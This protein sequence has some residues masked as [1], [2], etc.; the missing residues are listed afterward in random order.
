MLQVSSQLPDCGERPVLRVA[1]TLDL[2]GAQALLI[3][4]DD[5]SGKAPGGVD[6]DLGGVR[7]IDSEGVKSVVHAIGSYRSELREISGSVRRV[8]HLLR[9]EEGLRSA[10]AGGV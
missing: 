1:G 9:L 10:G 5:L 2:E 8:F 4:L 6:L 7:F 3:A